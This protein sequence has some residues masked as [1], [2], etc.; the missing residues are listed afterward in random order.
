MADQYVEAYRALIQSDYCAYCEYTNPGWIPSK[1]HRY[2]C[3]TVQDFVEEKTRNAF[4]VLVISCPPQHGKL[5]ADS[6]PVL[7]ADGWKTHGE[8]VV[9]DRVISPNGEFVRVTAVHPKDYTQYRIA[10]SN[11]ESFKCHGRHE[12]VVFDRNYGRLR[13]LE[14]QEMLKEGIVTNPKIR[15]RGRHIPKYSGQK[16]HRFR[17]PRREC[18]IGEEKNLPIHPYL[19]GKKIACGE[20]SD[21]P[22]EYLT[23]STDQRL[24]L[25]AGIIDN[26]SCSYGVEENRYGITV[27]ESAKEQVKALIS[28]FGWKPNERKPRRKNKCYI[29]FK[30]SMEIP[31]LNTEKRNFRLSKNTGYAVCSIEECE[32]EQGNCITVEGGV[33]CVGRTM[34]PTHNSVTITQTFPS[35]YLGHNPHNKVIEISYSEDFAETFGR[36]NREKIREYGEMLFGIS[37]SDSKNTATEFE[38]SN[39]QGGMLSRGIGSGVTGHGA[40]LMIIDDPIKTQQEADSD[41]TKNRIW[42]EWVSFFA[43]RL[44]PDAKVI[45]IMT[46]WAEDD[47]AGRLIEQGVN[48]KN[49]NLPLECDSEDD[50]LG[51]KV[52]DALCPEIGK[53]NEW[54]QDFK[55]FM[56]SREG[57]RTWNA[58]YQGHPVASIG[59][60]LKRE[61]WK[62]YDT[63]H[64]APEFIDMVMS[65]DAAFKDGSDNDFVAIQV[66]GKNGANIYLIDAVKKHLDMP[67]TCREIVRLRAMYPKCKITL[68]EDKA[69]GSAIIQVLRKQI[70]GIIG[71][72][73]DGGKVSRVN[74]VSGAIESGNVYLPSNKPF[75]EDFVNECAAFPNGAHDDQVDAMSQC[76]NRLIYFNS[77][78]PVAKIKTAFEIMFPKYHKEPKH[79]AVGYGDTIDVV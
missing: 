23:A 68:I 30:P 79:D 49:V 26:G 37:L 64:D 43:S 31:C 54:L 35:W 73:P 66:W 72:N 42:N 63:E 57:S 51:R 18:L 67:D 32:P 5:L 13:T 70:H 19:M 36:R 48:V 3:K 24:K 6:T 75:T 40:N 38:L 2:I 10:F 14:T 50:P 39:G 78:K 74:A 15:K 56:L 7:T 4:N 71:I 27:P 16:K 44:A 62:Y 28:T 55:R 8:L 29:R 77:N 53:G 25:I 12:W 61:W 34:I 41:A 59:N 11:G 45:I 47:L 33:Y 17:I 52:G 22:D 46:R 69:N 60:I 21:L 20:V 1:F 9:G 58:L 76:L 65:V